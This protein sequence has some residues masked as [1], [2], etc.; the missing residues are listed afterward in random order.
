M[1][2]SVY[3]KN[4]LGTLG[5]SNEHFS[6][7]YSVQIDGTSAISFDY[8][9]FSDR[10]IKDV[11]TS[12]IA[13][14]EVSD[15][16]EEN[17]YIEGAKYL[18][19]P[20]VIISKISHVRVWQVAPQKATLLNDNEENIIHLYFEKNRF[21]FMSSRLVDV[22]MGYSQLN[23]FE[24][25]GLIDFSREATCKILSAEF[26]KGLVAAKN[27]LKKKKNI[28]SR[29]LNNITSITM[30]IIAALII[31]SK[32]NP[33]KK[34]PDIIELLTYL[35]LR[36]KEYFDDKLMFK[37]GKELPSEIYK[38]LN[39]SINYQS[40]DHELLGYFYESTLLQFGERKAEIIRKE[41]G[42]YYTPKILSQEIVASI[43]F[44]SIPVDNRYVLDG[45][46]GSGSLLLSACKRLED[47]V[48]YEK[49]EFERHDYLTRMIEGNDIDK[50]ASEVAKLSLL[51]YSLPYGNKWNIHAGDLLCINASEIQ[52]PSVV[53]GNPPYKEARR[54]GRNTQKA[55]AFLD[56]YLEWLQNDG[57]IG[58]ILPESFLQNDSSIPQREKLLKEF[59]I[60]ELWILPGQIFENNCP[61]IV[62]IAQKKKVQGENI[63]KV[64]VLARNKKSVR[65]Y[66]KQRKWDFEFVVNIQQ[67]WK[68][69]SKYKMSVSPV[70]DILQKIAGNKK[71]ID[72][73]TQ[74]IVGI[75]FPSD[76]EFS[77]TEFNGGVP[78]IANAKHFRKYIVSHQMRDNVFFL[79]Y[80]MSK[81]EE[82]KI[83]EDY[84]YRGLRLRKNYESIYAASNKILVKRSSTPGDMNCIQAFVD[85]NGYYPSRSFFAIISEDKR[86]SNYVICALINSK[87][88]NAFVRRDCV[89][90]TLTTS[91][92]RSIPIPNFSD[93]QIAKI[94]QYYLDIKE[95][96]AKGDEY[97]VER[98]EEKIDEVIFEAFGLNRN[99]QERVKALFEVHTKREYNLASEKIEFEKYHHVSGQVEEIDV[100]SMCCSVCTVEFGEQNIKIEETMPGWFLRKGAE[101]S[102]KYYG[103]K[104]FDIK[105]LMYTYLDDEEIIAILN[106]E[107][108]Q[109]VYGNGN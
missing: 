89:K 109:E 104:L 63:T 82:N 9:A 21:E 69:D 47:L 4:M 58:I 36:Y 8:V 18:A 50:F 60:M 85:E 77:W 66:L 86:I 88:I 49:A 16:K 46:C 23:I 76:Y 42:I 96:Y 7:N 54:D 20:I 10:Y 94:H 78:Y 80:S 73:I 22:K 91:V 59:D 14:Q 102:A 52:M 17:K 44:E 84:D 93:A 6:E 43:P 5:Y 12:C 67:S 98:I 70:E 56:K 1:T 107:I 37:Y 61:T 87:I 95:A 65:N 68:D 30:H 2:K 13:V 41:F 97:K 25:F 101:F 53:L 99:E 28:I 39:C 24:V 92:V 48:R 55:T 62:I 40:V 106:G 64:K 100:E 38:K 19:T 34:V 103:G 15:D 29:D 83:I 11:S 45:T 74:N 27:Y 33:D 35:S 105:P 57:F 71:T 32:I 108:S 51:L 90:R 79:N 75:D 31:N 26:E 81:K 72:D 3:I